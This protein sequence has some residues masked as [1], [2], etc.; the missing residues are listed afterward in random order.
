MRFG[1]HETFAIRE[2]WLHKGL[3]MLIEE[4]DRLTDE[5]VADWLGVGRNMAKSIKFWLLT[6][7]LAVTRKTPEGK[8]DYQATDLGKLIRKQDPY[9]LL[10]G[11]WW[12]VHA[13]ILSIPN[14]ALTFKWFFNQF[15]HGRFDRAVALEALRRHL[16]AE[17]IRMPSNRTLERDLACVY[18]CYST[19][20]PSEVEDPEEG[21]ASPLRELG[22]I[23]FYRDSGYFQSD[24][25]PKKVP[26]ELLGYV[27]SLGFP[28]LR[29]SGRTFDV[30]IRK[31]HQYPSGPGRVFVLSSEALFD[32]LHEAE[33]ASS[34]TEIEIIGLAGQRVIRVKNIT[35]VDWMKQYYER[36][37]A[38]TTHAA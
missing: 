20:I 6:C 32:M 24:S 14:R 12:A 26:H 31:A 18:A 21:K 36:A 35:D 8:A 37:K 19:P 15:P 25:G 3:K 16:T 29:G 17:K 23:R 33:S 11:T 13:N 22:L 9:F 4:P 5:Y 28:E 34:S 1:G 27:L 30:P 10:D 38:V 7:G 2:G